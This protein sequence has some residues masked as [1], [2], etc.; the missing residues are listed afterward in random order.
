MIMNARPLPQA[1]VGYLDAALLDSR[2]RMRLLPASEFARAPHDHL[3]LWALKRSRY[4]LPTA[5][6]VTWLRT[7]IGD[8]RALEVGAGMGDLGFH[9]GIPMTDS[10]MQ[11]EPGMAAYYRALGQ[12][13]IAPPDDVLRFEAL[14][15]VKHFLPRVVIASWLTQLFQ[16]GDEREPKI[17]SSVY[18]ADEIAI[19]DRAETYIHIGNLGPH[20][21]KR[22]FRL[23]HRVYRLPFLF[24]RGFDREQ[25]RVWIWGPHERA[26][27]G[28]DVG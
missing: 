10:A 24:S 12:E 19:I 15:A 6:L 9:L 14:E 18:G 7:V 1:D 3:L 27:G 2:G 20:K 28:E 4:G 22:V 11:T 8:R 23:P 5:E 16:P 21:D 13:P 25:N 17:G 26:E